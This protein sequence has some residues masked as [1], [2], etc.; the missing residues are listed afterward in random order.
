MT[1]DPEAEAFGAGD[2]NH[3]QL[4]NEDAAKLLAHERGLAIKIPIALIRK[5]SDL[6]AAVILCEAAY[7]S[8]M[9]IRDD[10]WFDLPQRG[11]AWHG[12]KIIIVD[13][14][15]TEREANIF[16]KIG[17]WESFTG[18]SPDQQKAAR[19]KIKEIAPGVLEEKYFGIP[20]RLRY[21]VQ[22]VNFYR[23]L[24]SCGGA[25]CSPPRSPTQGQGDAPPPST[26]S[27]VDGSQRPENPEACVGDLRMQ[28]SSVGA[29]LR[30]EF[31]AAVPKSL[32]EL[33]K[34]E[35]SAA[36]RAETL[37]ASSSE[38]RSL[39]AELGLT[40]GQVG[41]LS[42]HCRASGAELQNVVSIVG[43]RLVR[44][45]IV[46][47]RAFAYLKACL[48]E[49][50]ARDWAREAERT[51]IEKAGEGENANFSH[52]RKIFLERIR[53]AGAEGIRL[54]NGCRVVVAGDAE[55]PE[56][57][58]RLFGPDSAKSYAIQPINRLLEAHADEFR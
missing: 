24:I 32:K 44:E 22:P 51:R 49:S 57:F 54:R 39:G 48:K 21:R 43:P 7:L 58:V 31:P 19:D 56:K 18:L 1:T 40:A 45:K 14:I 55:E 41:A 13:G 36:C 33:P 8:T 20:R 30:T 47:V 10:F 50:N 11:P 6:G 53:C 27:P 12:P 4:T 23:F 2:E 37:L 15:K 5:F 16:E 9:K 46:G 29:D 52:L 42:I 17:S 26:D 34:G 35:N 28:A 38:L 3:L 25:D